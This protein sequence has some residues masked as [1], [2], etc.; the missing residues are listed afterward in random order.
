MRN[1]CLIGLSAAAVSVLSFAPAASAGIP[2]YA[3]VGSF[4]LPAGAGT[5][6]VLPDGRILTMLGGDL[7]L[8]AVVNSAGFA[9]AGSVPA[10]L[11]NNF[12]ASFLKVSP[13][14]TRLAIGDGNFSAAAQ[15]LVVDAAS[16]NPASDSPV[17]AITTANYDAAWVDG[18]SLL[19]TGATA[20][21]ESIVSRVNT[22]A[23][24][25]R[26]VL[27]GVGDGSGGVAVRNGKAYIGVGFDLA[28]GGVATGDIR[29]FDLASLFT[30]PTAIDF[31]TSGILAAHAL[32]GGFM[33]FD[34]AGNLSVGGGDFSAE[35][36]FAAVLDGGA[37]E[38]ALL[39]GPFATS[40]TG[41][42]LAPAGNQFYSTLF[43]AATNELLVRA[44]GDDTVYR[45]AV[46]APSVG[47]MVALSGL[48]AHR[49]RRA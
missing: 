43:N 5:F 19:V 17:A 24:T 42:S 23:L 45:Y 30:T 15:V 41:Q 22:V 4:Q 26:T 16:L 12:G 37:I 38:A 34:P 9:K 44:F 20:S 28:P 18:S 47:M 31:G 33:S 36:G 7:H 49:R 3:L 14:G 46:P 11:I 40:A 21:F 10:A 2:N 27:S 29:A 1:R 35:S 32:S 48:F 6:D 8:Q 39:G 25:S 13:D